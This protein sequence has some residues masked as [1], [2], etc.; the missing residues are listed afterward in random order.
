MVARLLT[1]VSMISVNIYAEQVV[2][3][4]LV[5]IGQAAE[6]FE[7]KTAIF[8][9]DI[10]EKLLRKPRTLVHLFVG[11]AMGRAQLAQ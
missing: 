2:D 3:A 6:F 5:T 10:E 1:V 9:F 8:K 11:E 4:D 7:G